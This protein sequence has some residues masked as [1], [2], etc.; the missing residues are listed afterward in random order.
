ML[1]G[2]D[3][4]YFQRSCALL[5]LFFSLFLFV[6]LQRRRMREQIMK[7]R[8]AFHTLFRRNSPTAQ[9]GRAG[10]SLC[11]STPSFSPLP[12]QSLGVSV[13]LELI[14]LKL[15]YYTYCVWLTYFLIEPD[16]NM[17]YCS[18][19]LNSKITSASPQADRMETL[20]LFWLLSSAVLSCGCLIE[21][22]LRNF[23]KQSTK[24]QTMESDNT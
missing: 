2:P 15:G 12:P 23:P 4:T 10:G 16:W 17:L 3:L 20:P 6:N 1:D 11:N 21:A 18:T 7:R 22:S 19:R 9:R 13:I 8:S 24:Q 14:G 5:F